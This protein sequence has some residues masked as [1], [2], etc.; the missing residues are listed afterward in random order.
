MLRRQQICSLKTRKARRGWRGR[1]EWTFSAWPRR[2]QRCGA[3]LLVLAVSPVAGACR[4]SSLRGGANKA[5]RRIDAG[6]S[7]IDPL[8]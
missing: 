6:R 4:T 3:G 7:P 5:V 1:D 8:P 2:A